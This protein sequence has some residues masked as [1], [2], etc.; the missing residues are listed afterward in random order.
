VRWDEILI[1][2]VFAHLGALAMTP[3]LSSI[4]QADLARFKELVETGVVG[5]AGKS[6]P[7]RVVG[8]AG[9]PAGVEAAPAPAAD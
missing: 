3:I 8:S 2:P 1:P 6:A 9:R 7:A 5:S 4:F